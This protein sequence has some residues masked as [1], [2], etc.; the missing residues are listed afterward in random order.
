[1]MMYYLQKRK[2]TNLRGGIEMTS[3][4][5]KAVKNA[6]R[7]AKIDHGRGEV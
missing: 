4:E 1:M 3:K 5:M 7:A 6:K 2:A